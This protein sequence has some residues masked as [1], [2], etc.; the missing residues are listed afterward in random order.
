MVRI[1]ENIP[2]ILLIQRAG[3]P[4][5]KGYPKQWELTGGRANEG[6]SDEECLARRVREETGLEVRSLGVVSPELT[7]PPG[8]V[9][10]ASDEAVV[11]LCEVTG[12]ELT[13][14]PTDSHLD[15]RLVSVADLF[16][17]Q[18]QVL[19]NPTSKGYVSRMMTMV[20]AGFRAHQA[21]Q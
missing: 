1:E 12:G 10:Q 17:G 4:D 14:F 15:A 5:G 16:G 8:V 19:T 3:T 6:E 18:I 21:R 2:R 13:S 9:T 11:H 7:A 20:L